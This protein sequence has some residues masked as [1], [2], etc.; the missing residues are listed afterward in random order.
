MSTG[1]NRAYRE[2]ALQEATSEE[3]KQAILE[4]VKED[5]VPVAPINAALARIRIQV[6]QKDHKEQPTLIQ[7]IKSISNI[8]QYTRYGLM[9]AGG[10]ALIAAI[11]ISPMVTCRAIEETIGEEKA[12]LEQVEQNTG[13]NIPGE[14]ENLS[15]FDQ[16]V[17]DNET[18]S[19][20]EIIFYV[21]NVRELI[22]RDPYRNLEKT[23]TFI[24]G[25]R[26]ENIIAMGKGGDE[27]EVRRSLRILREIRERGG[28][29][30]ESF[31]MIEL[32]QFLLK[33]ILLPHLDDGSKLVDPSEMENYR[34]KYQL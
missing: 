3:Y 34:K 1:L 15:L 25:D 27:G 32:K 29:P 17:F 21:L 6:P 22:K 28:N 4:A 14:E 20:R 13:V 31:G 16:Y 10:G 26:L 5:S 11:G 12:A 9:A 2:A 7:R 19:A 8:R 24:G 18:F 23:Y 30:V 33:Q